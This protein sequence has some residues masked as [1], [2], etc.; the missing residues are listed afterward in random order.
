MSEAGGV[1][2]S[3]GCRAS[4]A[5]Y[6]RSAKFLLYLGHALSTW[7][8]RMWHFAVSV[9]LVELYGNSL[10]L[11]AV[12]GLVV[13]GS[14]L[15]LGA[16]I[17]DWV[18]KNA[19]L[20][21]ARTSLVVQNASVALCAFM[22]I[23]VFQY[24]ADLISMHRGWPLIVCYIVVIA[25]GNIANLASTATSITIQRDWI[26]VV[27]GE[28]RTNLAAMNATMR[29]IDQVT[30]IL[31]PLAVGQILT[32]GSLVIGCGF[33]AGWNV[34]SMGLEYLILWK[35]YQKTPA[36]AV[37]AGQKVDEQE[38]RQLKEQKDPRPD[39]M[40][41]ENGRLIDEKS[42]KTLKPQKMEESSCCDPFVKPLRT[43]R[44]A[45]VSYYK[46]PIFLAGMGLAF[47][48][49]T[50]LGFDSITTG[51]A[52]NQ[53]LSSSVLSILM[54]LSAV[55]GILG[56]VAFTWLQRRCGLV[57]TGFISGI[58][59]LCSLML[60]VVSVFLPAHPLDASFL[61]LGDNA[62]VKSLESTSS[63]AVPLDGM[64]DVNV[65]MG[66]GSSISSFSPANGDSGLTLN[67]LPYLSV[68]LL[69]AGIISARAGLWS[70][71]LTVTQLI[72]ENVIESERGIINGVQNSM[73]NLLDLLRFVM[74]IMAPNTESFGLLVLM[75]VS[76]VAMGHVMYFRYALKTLGKKLCDCCSV[77]SILPS[78]E[79]RGPP[80]ESPAI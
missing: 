8:D 72:Q 71:D 15:L 40:A 41:S 50:V 24:K 37:K 77:D 60:C 13:A 9:L 79:A 12:F 49:M 11:T 5:S 20:K 80:S 62:S 19:R 31:S 76:F 68:G 69:F 70:F 66:T 1:E 57:R 33:L 22:L 30:N 17:G 46:Q 56:T 58:A 47:L 38:M 48:Y 10:L 36:L 52:Y 39:V 32:F 45:W 42:L 14:V 53:G 67:Y 78:E 26:V 61:H 64:S 4:F 6:F 59:Q 16:L 23:F 54:G 29:R 35:V 21:V 73:N 65:T 74:V 7:G 2:T 51:Y 43:F 75:S 55:I 27:A 44:N 34:L 63:P 18:D 25:I 3:E 28:D